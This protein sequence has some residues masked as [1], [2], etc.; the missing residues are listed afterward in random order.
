[1]AEMVEINMGNGVG[2]LVVVGTESEAGDGLGDNAA[3][4]ESDIV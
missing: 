2:W 3:A 1:M 4:G